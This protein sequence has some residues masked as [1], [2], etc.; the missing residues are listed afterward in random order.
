[1]GQQKHRKSNKKGST[2]MK[3][4]SFY[5]LRLSEAILAHGAQSLSGFIPNF[6]ISTYIPGSSIFDPV[7]QYISNEFEYPHNPY[8]PSKGGKAN[9]YS[10]L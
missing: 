5:V 2:V 10:N 7:S 4:V 9:V 8:N 1:M 3:K 6:V